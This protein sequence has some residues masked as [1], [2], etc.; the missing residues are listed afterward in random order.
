[1]AYRSP[2]PERPWR[3]IKPE[4]FKTISMSIALELIFLPK[5]LSENI[6]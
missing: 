1:M 4:L 3:V 2:A 5:L 6:N